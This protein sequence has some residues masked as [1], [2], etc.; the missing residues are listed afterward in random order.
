M[1]SVY[2]GSNSDP[3]RII[4]RIGEAMY[5]VRSCTSTTVRPGEFLGRRMGS[6]NQNPSRSVITRDNC[7]TW[8]LHP[9]YGGRS[10]SGTSPR[11]P[12]D[13]RRHVREARSFAAT[14]AAVYIKDPQVITE[15]INHARPIGGSRHQGAI[16]SEAQSGS[17]KEGSRRRQEHDR[18]ND[19][20][21]QDHHQ[22]QPVY[23]RHPD[24]I[25]GSRR[26]RV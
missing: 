15:K 1:A 18:R 17:T 25:M 26:T 19:A 3:V 13:Y 20:S 9:A 7:G 22:R 16:H 21:G 6:P 2:W 4:R 14:L 10:G 12:T 23:Q 8:M 24:E 11:S 5:G